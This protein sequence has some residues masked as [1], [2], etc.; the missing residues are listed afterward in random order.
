LS[1][2]ESN[3]AKKIAVELYNEVESL[4]AENPTVN[5][6]QLEHAEPVKNKF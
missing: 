5:K 2:E 6:G 1:W 4:K 3:L